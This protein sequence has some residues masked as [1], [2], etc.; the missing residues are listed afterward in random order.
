MDPRSSFPRHVSSRSRFKSRE[1]VSGVGDAHR[2]PAF[3]LTQI[4]HQLN[5]FRC[6]ELPGETGQGSMNGTVRQPAFDQMRRFPAVAEGEIDVGAILGPDEMQVGRLALTSTVSARFAV[7][8][9][10]GCFRNRRG[11]W[12]LSPM[13]RRAAASSSWMTLRSIWMP[14]G[15]LSFSALFAGRPQQARTFCAIDQFRHPRVTKFVIS[16]PAR[17]GDVAPEASETGIRR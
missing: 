16:H 8:E 5:G 11:A 10:A 13:D 9:P 2:R 17:V 3:L 1:P 4:A 15:F 12:S 6:G 14:A 7:S